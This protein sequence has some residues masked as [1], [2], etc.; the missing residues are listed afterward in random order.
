MANQYWIR[1]FDKNGKM[2]AET[3]AG[4]SIGD[5]ERAMNM[6]LARPGGIPMETAEVRTYCNEQVVGIKTR[7]ANS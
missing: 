5:A 6:I 3:R 2:L 7:E 1:A 4:R